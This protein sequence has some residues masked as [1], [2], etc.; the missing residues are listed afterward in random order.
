MKLTKKTI[1]KL[2]FVL[3]VTGA[4]AY[5]SCKQEKTQRSNEIESSNTGNSQNVVDEYLVLGCY[6]DL[7]EE[8]QLK[9]STNVINHVVSLILDDGS[10][11]TNSV[12]VKAY[13][14]I[15]ASDIFYI[16]SEYTKGTTEKG[17]IATTLFTSG[18]DLR[19]EK[20]NS[21]THSCTANGTCDCEIWNLSMCNGHSC[22]K[23]CDDGESG[24]CS[25]SITGAVISAPTVT[26]LNQQAPE[27]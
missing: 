13:D 23:R 16:K 5:A 2:L 4:I 9:Y 10:A 17:E 7:S 6:N 15:A 19:F 3:I 27:C 24:G 26:Y 25:S 11:I 14:S 21:C 12:L 22:H 8:G 20:V 1:S 18:I